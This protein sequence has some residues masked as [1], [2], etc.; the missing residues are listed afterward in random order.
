[1]L[2]CNHGNAIG[3]LGGVELGL[4]LEV[5]RDVVDGVADDVVLEV[6]VVDEGEGVHADVVGDDEL[7]PGETCRRD[8]VRGGGVLCIDAADAIS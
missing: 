8:R 5:G 4:V 6:V 1:M 7:E 2:T 3:E